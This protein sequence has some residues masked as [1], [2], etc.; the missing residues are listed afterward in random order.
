MEKRNVIEDERTPRMSKQ[1][2]FD[3]VEKQVV[4]LFG[5]K[6]EKHADKD[7]HKVRE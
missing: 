2:E 4:E 7:L 3:A 6:D 1:A 5:A